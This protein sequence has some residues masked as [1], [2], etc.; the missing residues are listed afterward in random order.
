MVSEPRALLPVK[1]SRD[2][3]RSP[4]DDSTIR[5]INLGDNDGRE[6]GSGSNGSQERVVQRV[7][8]ETTGSV[9]YPTLTRTNYTDWVLVMRVNL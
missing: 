7:V 1:M 5:T 2:D 4:T 3:S 8:R 6:I 9:V